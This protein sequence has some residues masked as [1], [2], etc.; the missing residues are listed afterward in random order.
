MGY[1]ALTQPTSCIQAIGYYCKL[2]N[3]RLEMNMPGIDA[4][5][6]LGPTRGLYRGKAVSGGSGG[7]EVLPM[8]EFLGSPT[9]SQNLVFP[10][11]PNNKML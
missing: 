11:V 7:S 10:L 4:E 9:L 5:S 1:A 3:E 6:P 2:E 8:Q